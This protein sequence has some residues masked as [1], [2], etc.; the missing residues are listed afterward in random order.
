MRFWYAPL[1]L[2]ALPLMSQAPEQT[3][4]AQMPATG[5]VLTLDDAITLAEQNAF[6]LKTAASNVEIAHQRVTQSQG[7]LGPQ[8]SANL[9]Y[10]QI[11][12]HSNFSGASGV[13]GV[14]TGTTGG[15]AGT[16]GSTGLSSV[17][18]FVNTQDGNA[19]L[20]LPIDI[21]GN[22]RHGVR[23]AR[24]AY[25]ASRS[26]FAEADNDLRLSVRQSYFQILEDKAQISVAQDALSNAQATLKNAQEKLAAGTL[27]R[28][29]VLQY[30]TQLSQAESDLLTDQN[31]LDTA[32]ESFNNV[33]ARP[34]D[35]AFDVADVNTLPPVPT[36]ADAL[37]TQAISSR[38]DVQ[39]DLANIKSLDET[40][41]AT[42]ATMDPSLAVGLN[43]TRIFF[44]GGTATEFQESTAFANLTIPI[45]DS[46]ITRAKV[47][48][49]RQNVVQAQIALNQLKLSI[50]LEVRQDL[51]NLD[52]ASAKLH[53]AQKQVEQ[54]QEQYRLAVVRAN[55]GEGITL[56]VTNAQAQLTTART[57]L[58]NARYAYLIA[59]AELQ[60]AI[61]QDGAK[62]PPIV[63][64]VQGKY[65]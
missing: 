4:P 7:A 6:S 54:A 8:L 63:S 31:N 19:S 27:A 21:S 3:P 41:R 40:R 32:K 44:P 14:T 16:T 9:S 65:K 33:L 25:Q 59:Y 46:G 48:E 45:W 55:A 23:A 11:L 34:I 26:T 61:D 60:K 35:T 29:D 36:D 51:S 42:E 17:S 22:L 37:V 38:P 49:A 15:T 13:T 57:G 58:V 64:P 10:S 20:S 52:S 62:V 56:D 53:V 28:Y 30:E 5:P 12:G 1:A 43:H 24:A 2:A 47:K 39:A 50:S 18:T